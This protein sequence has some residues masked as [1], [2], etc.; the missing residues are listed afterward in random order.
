MPRRRASLRSGWSRS[1]VWRTSSVN[2]ENLSFSNT[3]TPSV[4][5]TPSSDATHHTRHTTHHGTCAVATVLD[6]LDVL[7]HGAERGA[8]ENSPV[9][10]SRLGFCSVTST[11]TRRRGAALTCTDAPSQD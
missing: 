2:I 4:S 5:S 10:P 7:S 6:P 1:R 3:R 9:R 8:G 11:G